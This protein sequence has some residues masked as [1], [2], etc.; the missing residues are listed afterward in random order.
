MRPLALESRVFAAASAALLDEPVE[1][2]RA[3]AFLSD[4][5]AR[6]PAKVG[7]GVRAVLWLALFA[8][9]LLAGRVRT[10]LSLPRDEA[11]ALWTRALDHRWY[12]VRQLALL[13]KAFACML[14]YDDD[15]PEVAA[16]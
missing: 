1:T 8:P 5:G 13:L 12:G 15:A 9:L 7:W 4:L 11:A 3:S 10:L 16:R 2:A 6:T 14:R